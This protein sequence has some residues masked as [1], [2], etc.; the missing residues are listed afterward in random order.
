MPQ[1]NVWLVGL[2]LKIVVGL[3]SVA[4]V[5]PLLWEVFKK[6]IYSVQLHQMALLKIFG[7]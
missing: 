1:V 4:F 2:P 5:M 7:G 6:Q 3:G